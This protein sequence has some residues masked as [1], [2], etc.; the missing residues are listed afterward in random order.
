MFLY[1]PSCVHR[2]NLTLQVHIGV[3]PEELESLETEL[4]IVVLT[5]SVGIICVVSGT[6]TKDKR[7]EKQF[8]YSLIYSQTINANDYKNII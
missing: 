5:T 3:S 2:D 8:G 6:S 4:S 1:P 7:R